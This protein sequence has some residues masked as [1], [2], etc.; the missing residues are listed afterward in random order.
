MM[1]SGLHFR[2]V[3]SDQQAGGWA[4]E[5]GQGCSGRGCPA[6]WTRKLSGG[7]VAGRRAGKLRVS[8]GE[9]DRP[10]DET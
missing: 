6:Q 4:R 8:L 7:G 1:L 2:R 10:G 5:T 9:T 3:A